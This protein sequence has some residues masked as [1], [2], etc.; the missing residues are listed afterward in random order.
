M[1]KKA[2]KAPQKALAEAYTNEI[3]PAHIDNIAR[4]CMCAGTEKGGCR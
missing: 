3:H 1:D 4:Y 2:V